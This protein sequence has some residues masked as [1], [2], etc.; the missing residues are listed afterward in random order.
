MIISTRRVRS[1]DISDLAALLEELGFPATTA[2]IE[3]RFTEVEQLPSD[4]VFVAV[5]EDQV[6]GFV[7]LHVMPYFTSGDRVCRVMTLVVQKAMRSQGI[8]KELIRT[9]EA[10][11]REAGCSAIEVTSAD[12]RK[13]A[14]AFYAR[15]G[16]PQISVKFYKII[17][18]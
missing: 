12:Y 2:E 10:F 1:T 5:V 6:V 4:A 3:S 8:G 9:V 14:H 11:A 13:D 7:S 15:Q 17:D 18:L 16:Y